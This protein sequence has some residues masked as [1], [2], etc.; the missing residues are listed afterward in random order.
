MVAAGAEEASRDCDLT[1]AAGPA[2]ASSAAVTGVLAVAFGGEKV[3][4]SGEG[5][6]VGAGG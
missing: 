1:V 6:K 5:L 3:D 2:W 4:T